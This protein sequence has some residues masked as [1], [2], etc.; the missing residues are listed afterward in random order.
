MNPDAKV[1]V[2]KEWEKLEKIPAWQLDKMKSKKDVILEAQREKRKV[3]FALLMDICHLKSAELEAKY[4]KYNGRVVL[5]DIEQDDSGSNAV[6]TEG[7]C[8]GCHCKT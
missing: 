6:F 3:H 2:G 8:D 7:S 5:R 4:R 1:A